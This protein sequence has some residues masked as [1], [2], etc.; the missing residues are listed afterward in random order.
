MSRFTQIL[1]RIFPHE[2]LPFGRRWRLFGSYVS[3]ITVTDG[4]ILKRG[5]PWFGD[6]GVYLHHMVR[7]DSDRH[8]HNHP[9]NYA[10]LILRGGYCEYVME[11]D[12]QRPKWT[13]PGEVHFK[14]A[15]HLHKIAILPNGSAWTLVFAGK[16][17][18]MPGPHGKPTH[19]WGFKV[20]AMWV[21]WFRYR[22]LMAKN[23]EVSD[24][25]R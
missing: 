20:G 12:A 6:R 9:W 5:L 21:P 15:D 11:E 22:E 4:K 3:S 16:A 18:W 7:V 14:S 25:L 2:D 23:K 24:G 8:L 19:R 17:R 1:D 10:T 13:R